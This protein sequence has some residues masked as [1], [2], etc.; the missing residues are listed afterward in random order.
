MLSTKWHFG[1]HFDQNTVII[2][3]NSETHWPRRNQLVF[4][5]IC[6]GLI[7]GQL[8]E[9]MLTPNNFVLD[10]LLMLPNLD[11]LRK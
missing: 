11:E 2:S 5:S 7:L 3:R 4:L 9:V 1:Y 8:F 10:I 6:Y